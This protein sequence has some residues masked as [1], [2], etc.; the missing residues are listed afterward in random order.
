MLALKKGS[1]AEEILYKT[2]LWGGGRQLPL[3]LFFF[4]PFGE[5]KKKKLPLMS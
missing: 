5:K 1:A 2:T 3:Y 4:S